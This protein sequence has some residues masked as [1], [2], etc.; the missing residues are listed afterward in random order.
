MKKLFGKKRTVASVLVVMILILLL[1]QSQTISWEG[2]LRS[3]KAIGGQSFF[4]ALCVAIAQ[5]VSVALR[6]V[7]LM[8]KTSVT[9][10]QC[11]RIF[12]N[13]QL[14]NHVF[15]ARAGD[16]YKVIALKRSSPDKSFS[17]AYVVSALII[18]RLVSTLVLVLLIVFLVD[19]STLRIADLSFVGRTQQLTTVVSVAALAGVALYFMQKKF[20]RLHA[21]LAELKRSFF[22]ILNVRTFILVVCMSIVMW[23]LEVWSIKFLAIPL[24]VDLQLGQGL[25]VLL[26]LNVGIAVPVTLGNVGTYEAALV[27]GL[28]LWGAGSND[29]IAIAVSHHFLQI[30][31][32]VILAGIFNTIN[33]KMSQQ[34][35]AAGS[36]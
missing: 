26:L 27:L 22:T 30:L 3:L 33:L 24:G 2:V 16:L 14:F 1:T 17:T 8:S 11:S 7:V 9:P 34:K 15:P 4:L 10:F 23:V 19:W 36:E 32:L 5:Y 20:P 25:F 18:E 21:W 13:G 6:F 31:S 12:T 28:G 29:G 35:I